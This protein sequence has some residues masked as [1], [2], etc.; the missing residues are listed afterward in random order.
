M[1][2]NYSLLIES[3]DQ[4]VWDSCMWHRKPKLYATVTLDLDDNPVSQT[5]V[6]KRSLEPKWNFNSNLL[7]HLTSTITLQLHHHTFFSRPDDPVVGQCRI[8]IK[9]LLDQCSSGK[10]IHLE[11][12]ADG[13]VSGRLSVLLEESKVAAGRAKGRME[14]AL[15]TLTTTGPNLDRITAAVEAGGSHNDLATALGTCLDH[16][17]IVVKMGDKLAQACDNLLE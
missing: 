10:V 7:C 2:E 12:K 4:I 11:I 14:S 13:N 3:A 6:F 8:G 15:V 5:P 9:E 17:D 1:A 16:I